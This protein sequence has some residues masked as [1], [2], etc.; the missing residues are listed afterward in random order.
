MKVAVYNRHWA[1][2]GGGERFAGG[3]A[4]V[5]AEDHQVTLLAH[6]AFDPVAL[7]ERLQLDLSG[8]TLRVVGPAPEA[9]TAASAEVDLFINA[10]YASDDRAAAAHNVYV[11]HFPAL[12]PFDPPRSRRTGISLSARV[13]RLL[14]VDPQPARIIDGAY[15]AEQVGHWPARWTD[16]AARLVVDGGGAVAVVLGRF[17]PA[18]AG[19]LH[20]ELKVG[21]ATVATT[22]LAPRRR[23]QDPPL[24]LLRADLSGY[25]GPVELDLASTTFRPADEGGAD[26]R[27]LGAPLVAVVAGRRWELPVQ[28]VHQLLAVPTASAAFLADYQLVAANSVFT[29]GWVRRLW[30]RDDVAVLYPP[31]TAQPASVGEPVILGVGRF[32]DPEA[33][34]GKRQV[35][36]VDAFRR[37]RDTGGA[38][39]WSLHLAGGCDRLGQPYLERVRAASEGLDVHVHV[40]ATGAELRS[41]YAR[42]SVFWHLTGLGEDP[43]LHPERFEHFGITTV[44]AMSAGI[45]PVVLGRAGQLE[46]FDDGVAGFHIDDVPQLV[47]RTLALIEDPERRVAM[48]TAAVERAQAFLRPAFARHLRQLVADL[49]ARP[50]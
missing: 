2:G 9:V 33:G 48:A 47:D 46:L 19:D 15:L 22:S 32:F 8:T 14:G 30:G 44:E 26:G 29:Q 31:V 21:G 12:P 7:G 27:T 4:E 41:L 35:E 43:E 24:A 45:V 11:V 28:A 6:E 1:T 50:G 38:P 25:D 3:I 17:H 37:L 20:V 39:G 36:L 5:L 16:G 23:R 42:A 18:S 40:N 49:V 10:S 34:H 13:A